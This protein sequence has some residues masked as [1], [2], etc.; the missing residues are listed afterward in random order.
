M[1][2][3]HFPEG[4][5]LAE[6]SRVL[7]LNYFHKYIYIYVDVLNKHVEFQHC[8]LDFQSIFRWK[9]CDANVLSEFI[10]VEAGSLRDHP[11]ASSLFAGEPLSFQL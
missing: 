1:C 6:N 3:S 4:R 9:T 11:E 8:F 10:L 7:I 2:F 5:T